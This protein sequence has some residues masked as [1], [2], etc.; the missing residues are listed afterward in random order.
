MQDYQDTKIIS[1]L[2]TE[3]QLTLNVAHI[4]SF[5]ILV[6]CIIWMGLLSVS[7]CLTQPDF[8]WKRAKL[9]LIVKRKKWGYSIENGPEVDAGVLYNKIRSKTEKVKAI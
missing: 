4:L 6:S 9:H 3:L 8:E 1:I 2:E 5:H 7:G